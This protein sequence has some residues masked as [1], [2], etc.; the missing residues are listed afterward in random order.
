M[1]ADGGMAGI[2]GRDVVQDGLVQS[3][4]TLKKQ[5]NIELIASETIT[6]GAGS[7]TASLISE[8]NET[9]HSS[10][11]LTGGSISLIAGD[12]DDEEAY[13]NAGRII[14]KGTILAPSGAVSLNA[15]ER[16]FLEN[17]SRIDVSGVWMFLPISERIRTVTLN[18]QELKDD[19]GQ[20]ES[21]LKGEEITFDILSGSAIGDVSGVLS[22]EE[23]TALERAAAGGEI[24]LNAHYGEVIAKRGASLDFSGG[25]VVYGSGNIVT[26]QVLADN[27]IY[28]I[29]DVSQWIHIRETVDTVEVGNSRYGIYDVFTGN[30]FGGAVGGEQLL[31]RADPR[32]GRR[33]PDR[34]RQTG[35]PQRGYGR[36]GGCRMGADRN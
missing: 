27:G 4:T 26:T 22:A 2:Y 1:A 10:F 17:G 35:D 8:S 14:H 23:L 5:G 16:V 29:S 6:T 3:M 33:H 31:G 12:A 36:L 25:G 19:Q 21:V 28:D 11:K 20:K 24:T 9:G 30:Y 7:L 32:P 18:S 34:H 13:G 15:G